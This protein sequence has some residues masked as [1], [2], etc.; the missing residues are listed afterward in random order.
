MI[1]MKLDTSET[2]RVKQAYTNIKTSL[3]D[4]VTT[5]TPADRSLLAGV[6]I[7]DSQ[8]YM[9]RFRTAQNDKE[10]FNGCDNDGKL[11][12]YGW[13]WYPKKWDLVMKALQEGYVRLDAIIKQ[14]DHL[15]EAVDNFLE[16]CIAKYNLCVTHMQEYKR[17]WTEEI[18]PRQAEQSHFDVD[19]L[20]RRAGVLWRRHAK[21]RVSFDATTLH[22]F[23]Q[24]SSVVGAFVL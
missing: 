15:G 7:A 14:D 2:T 18:L 5:C 9:S 4:L 10:T 6:K 3:D 1:G 24:Q 17:I 11:K 8:Y 23:L 20:L 21:P 22:N 19:A 13:D 12:Y 16:L